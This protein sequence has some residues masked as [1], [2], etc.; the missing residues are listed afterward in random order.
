MNMSIYV[1]NFM[2]ICMWVFKKMKEVFFFQF[3]KIMKLVMWQ[4]Q[5]HKPSPIFVYDI[6]YTTIYDEL[7][8]IFKRL[9]I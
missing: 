4:T 9:A 6:G 2:N 8:M 7:N 5:C 1:N 3:L